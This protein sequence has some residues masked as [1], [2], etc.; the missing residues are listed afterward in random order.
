[1]CSFFLSLVLVSLVLVLYFDL[2]IVVIYNNLTGPRAEPLGSKSSHDSLLSL[3]YT[4]AFYLTKVHVY[5][6]HV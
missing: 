6:L 1:M 3:Y 5:V 4:M 2:H